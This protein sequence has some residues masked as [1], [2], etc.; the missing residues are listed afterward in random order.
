MVSNE[1][2]ILSACIEETRSQVDKAS[3][4]AVNK[5]NSV[6]VQHISSEGAVDR[7]TIKPDLLRAL[8]VNTVY[9]CG[10]LCREDGRCVSLYTS[11]TTCCFPS[12]VVYVCARFIG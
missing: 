7:F 9:I 3:G 8:S 2:P 11:S 12:V 6:W 5:S 4:C 10:P 1:S